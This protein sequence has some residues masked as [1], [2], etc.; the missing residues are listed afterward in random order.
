MLSIDGIEFSF[1]A[2]ILKGISFEAKRGDFISV[3]G[4]NGSGKT[5]LLRCISATLKP[6]TGSVYIDGA[7][8]HGMKSRDVAKNFA[9]VEQSSP[10]GYELSVRDL[11]ML[12]RLP[13]IPRFASPSMKDVS[14]V[15][16]ALSVVE[17]KELA[18]RQFDELSGG[19]KQKVL[20]ALAIAQNT[21]V[22]LLDEPTA[23]LDMK[24]QLEIMTLLKRLCSEDRIVIMA[25]HNVSSASH[26]SDKVLLLRDGEQVA[27]GPPDKIIR[28]ELIR[29]VFGVGLSIAK[30][31][32][33]NSEKKKRIHIICGGGTGAQLMEKLYDFELSVGVVNLFDSDTEKAAELGAE[34]VE[35][36]PFSPIS[37]SSFEKNLELIKRADVVVVT[38]FP[39]GTGNVKNIE[40][41]LEAS[42]MGKKV[43]MLGRCEDFSGGIATD[44]I[45]ELEA[46]SSIFSEEHEL[47]NFLRSI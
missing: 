43:V 4:P 46:Q 24:A 23:H 44:P 7:N 12:G 11:I 32:R 16:E 21:K 28:E 37:D 39:V 41:A 18:D 3:L 1:D 33:E 31:M 2:K 14:A 22:L 13:H 38:G 30:E 45:R 29:E 27:F 40:A 17:I 9:F 36:L 42:K 47:L 19:E 20:I 25:T 8:V 10:L 5:T 26:F 35:E 6:Q 15:D 34:I